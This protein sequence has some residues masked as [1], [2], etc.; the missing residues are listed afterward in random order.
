MNERRFVNPKYL[1]ST[2]TV[3]PHKDFIEVRVETGGLEERKKTL[4]DMKTVLD[5]IKKAGWIEEN[6]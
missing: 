5:T 2:L 4:K 3:I 6:V 1:L